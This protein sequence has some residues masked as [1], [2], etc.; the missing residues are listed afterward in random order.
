M[1][2]LLL[3][4]NTAGKLAVNAGLGYSFFR[5]LDLRITSFNPQTNITATTFANVGKGAAI[6]GNLNINYPFTGQWNAALNSNLVYINMDGP[7]GN[8][9]I[10][11]NR[12]MYNVNLSSAYRFQQ[13]WR[14]SV[15][16]T[17]A[18]PNIASLQSLSNG[19]FSSTFSIS[20]DLLADRL[21]LAAGISNPFSQYRHNIVSTSD[22]DFMGINDT[23]EYFRSCNFS[24][25]YRF[26][27]LKEGIRKTRRGINNDDV[28]NSKGGL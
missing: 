24:L 2:N 19:L 27:K 22:A 26:G 4:Y 20:K 1:N 18:G 5:N 7:S 8:T 21:S 11:V 15:S 9:L 3:G 14:C 23:R 10:K 6:I 28:S 13:S 17:A 16:L 12:V 25:N